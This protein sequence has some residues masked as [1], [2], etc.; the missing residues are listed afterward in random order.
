MRLRQRP[1]GSFFLRANSGTHLCRFSVSKDMKECVMPEIVIND[2]T[3][4]SL[5]DFDLKAIADQIVDNYVSAVFRGEWLKT[6]VVKGLELIAQYVPEEVMKY[7]G[8]VTDGI[9]EGELK[10]IEDEL[11]DLLDKKIDIK[12]VPDFLE[13]MIFRTIV[14]GLL[15]LAKQ[16]FSFPLKVSG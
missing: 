16:G 14:S 13:P 4:P 11:V 9:S 15:N 1:V 5:N 7:I 12:R 3:N 8:M 2:E 10:K 6:W